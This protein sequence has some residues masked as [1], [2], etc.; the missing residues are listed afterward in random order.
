MVMNAVN[1]KDVD[2]SA[3]IGGGYRFNA[4]HE[5]LLEYHAYEGIFKDDPDLSQTSNE[6]ILG[7]RYYLPYAAFELS[8]NENIIN[9]DN[10]ADIAFT[11]GL[12]LFL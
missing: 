1:A 7:Y 4:S 6:I 12:R 9:M 11:A 2:W 5:M 3:A 8:M 10:T